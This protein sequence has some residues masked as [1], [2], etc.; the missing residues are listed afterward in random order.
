MMD[1]VANDV[2]HALRALARLR[3]PGLLALATLAL[4]I[5]AT[6]TM[7]GVVDAALLRPPPFVQPDRL[8]MVSQ[9]RTTPRD[10]TNRLRWSW[11]HIRELQR[12]TTTFDAMAS[13]TGPVFSLSGRGD[14]EQIDGEI[15]S[16]DYFRVMRAVPMAGRV[17]TADESAR[18]DAV[19]LVSARL[20]QRR[21]ASD[22]AMVGRTVR[23][24][25][26]P[27]TVIGILPDGFA[28]LTGKADVWISPPMSTYL[29]YAEY[30]V[31][32]QHFISVVARLKDGITIAEANAA[33]ASVAGG[34]GDESPPAA[35]WSAV[36]VPVGKARVDAT[37]R[38][39]ALVLLAASVCVLVIACVNI[40]SLLLAR[41]RMRRREIAIRLAI[42]SSRIGLVRLLLTE[43]LVM[44]AVAGA[45]GAIVA[46]WGLSVFARIAPAV[47]PT[48][49][50]DYGVFAA[51]TAR[52]DVRVLLFALAVSI[53]TTVL[54]ALAPAWSASKTDLTSAQKD[55][56][57]GSGRA[58]RA[59]GAFVIAE[60]ALAVLLLAGAGLLLESFASIQ[61]R[62]TG[63]NG[64]NVLTFW[65]RPPAARYDYPADGPSIVER[66]LTRVQ[67]VPGVAFAAVNRC[68]P[69]TG[70]A[71]S[72][73]FLP[74]QP[75]AATNA[76]GVGRHYISTD[77]FRTLGI[78]LIAGRALTPAD[79]AGASPVA[80]VNQA[81]ARRFWPGQNPIGQHVWF[82]TTTGPF[83]PR[84]RPVEIV[85]VVGDVKYEPVDQADDPARADFYTSYLQ[86]SYPD[87]MVLVKAVDGV[88]AAESLVPALRTAVASVDD[89]LPIFDVMMLDERIDVA[90]ARPRFNATL[91]ATFAASALLL[92]ALGIYSVLSY[93]VSSRLREI[94]IR[95]ALGAD[96]TS[97]LALVLGDGLRLAGAGAV[98]GIVG[99]VAV[100]RVLRSVL[101]GV[102]ALG[103]STVALSAGVLF[104]VTALAAFVPARLA[105]RVDPAVVLRNE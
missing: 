73:A 68:T 57:R 85:G 33:L 26:V 60:T 90:V 49:R 65:V 63:F 23:L 95:L 64:E 101:V 70:C 72:V 79:R 80:V 27:V 20:W 98:I 55:D 67:A 35:R 97:V 17:F 38:N 62:R 39:S 105:S 3:A 52:L 89:G 59:L 46:G 7:F 104:A 37:V 54:F 14:P 66:I 2:R 103:A 78:P 75:I 8:V 19:A 87:T 32:P 93:A 48:S 25:D 76:P 82:G 92:A 34:L 10:G 58:S 50:N 100:A 42:G 41:G 9:T 28:G 83:S 30:L 24:N 6:T 45:G 99:A 1:S 102:G 88:P 36:A 91:L 43:G 61:N 4:G 84:E 51:Y 16:P 77:Y 74:G 29:A 15:V 71:R 18:A 21:F 11:P 40:A 22:P 47:I 12:S 31:T 69:F 94:G 5:G 13:I 56:D 53:G 44:A 96:S 86:F 81:G